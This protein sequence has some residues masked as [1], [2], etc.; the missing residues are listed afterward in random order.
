MRRYN[1]KRTSE[2]KKSFRASK[3]TKKAKFGVKTLTLGSHCEL[4]AGGK[5]CEFL[6]DTGTD[7][8]YIPRKMYAQIFADYPIEYFTD[9]KNYHSGRLP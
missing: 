2:K 9:C 1:R 3:R 7:L 4:K 6:I 8:N 5:G